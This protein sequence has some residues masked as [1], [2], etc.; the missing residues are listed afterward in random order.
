M[1]THIETPHNKTML[2]LTCSVNGT[3]VLQ[4]CDD[5]DILIETFDQVAHA[6]GC[7]NYQLFLDRE[8]ALALAHAIRVHFEDVPLP[9]E[10]QPAPPKD[11]HY[12][13]LSPLCQKVYQHMQRAGSISAREAQD[14]Y[15]ITSAS[16]ARRICDIEAEGFGITRD[17]K[18][19]P[20]T[21]QRYTR[22]SLAA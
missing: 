21:E 20:I 17:R 6:F 9:A 16:L 11:P 13:N 5:G 19:H 2:E 1:H 7:E 4:S 18:V 10:E 14:D 12:S 15:G 3:G 8:Q 22:Y